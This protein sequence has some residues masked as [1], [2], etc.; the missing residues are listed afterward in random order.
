MAYTQLIH[1]EKTD[2]VY[3]IYFDG[4]GNDI[5]FDID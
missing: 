3:N 5:K 1:L 2:Y 4:P